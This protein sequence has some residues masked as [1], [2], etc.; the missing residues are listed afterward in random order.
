MDIIVYVFAILMFI[1]FSVLWQMAFVKVFGEYI[2]KLSRLKKT[3]V[4]TVVNYAIPAV[5]AYVIGVWIAQAF[6]Y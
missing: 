4:I 3:I 5:I 2:N 6:L 1:G